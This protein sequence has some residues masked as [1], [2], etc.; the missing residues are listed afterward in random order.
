MKSKTNSSKYHV[1][2]NSLH[3]SRAKDIIL[4]YSRSP[5]A[6]R[7]PVLSLTC[8]AAVE[9]IHVILRLDVLR[10]SVRSADFWSWLCSW[11]FSC[12][13]GILNV[14]SILQT[15][16]CGQRLER[17]NNEQRKFYCNSRYNH[18]WALTNDV[19]YKNGKRFKYLNPAFHPYKYTYLRYIYGALLCTTNLHFH[20]LPRINVHIVLFT[21]HHAHSWNFI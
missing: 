5:S 6:T 11:W 7:M 17:F 20:Y 16:S 21:R 19:S 10:Q 13:W 14:I 3:W 15:E 4:Q 18:E 9:T 1:L 2:S 8:S 12:L